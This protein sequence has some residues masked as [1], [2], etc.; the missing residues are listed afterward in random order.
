MDL[1]KAIQ[2]LYVEKKRLERV[3]ASLEE[4]QRAARLRVPPAP[5]GG[6]RVGRKPMLAQP[7]AGCQSA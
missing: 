6:K 2:Y 7:A 5:S 1:Y 4:L 3:I